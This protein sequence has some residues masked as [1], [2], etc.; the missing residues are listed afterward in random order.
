MDPAVEETLKNFPPGPLCAYRSQASF[1]W[2]K[3]GLT[4][5]GADAILLKVD[6]HNIKA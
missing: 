5:Q 1:C 3:M 2:K 6:A 4:M